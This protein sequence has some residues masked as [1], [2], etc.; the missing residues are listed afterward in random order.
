MRLGLWLVEGGS[1]FEKIL[2]TKIGLPNRS[3]VTV[4][5]AKIAPALMTTSAIEN[6]NIRNSLPAAPP[7]TISSANPNF[8][9]PGCP[10][11]RISLSYLFTGLVNLFTPLTPDS[12]RTREVTRDVRSIGSETRD[13]AQE[14]Q[15]SNFNLSFHSRPYSVTGSPCLSH[16]SSNF[17]IS[18]KLWNSKMDDSWPVVRGRCGTG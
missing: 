9:T 2:H 15:P 17:P 14:V 18:R 10:G 4:H 7:S 3:T 6:T 11:G 1:V 8:L 16:V 13:E 12:E 5:R